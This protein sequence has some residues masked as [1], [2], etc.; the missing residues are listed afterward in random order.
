M[1]R[2]LTGIDTAHGPSNGSAPPMNGLMGGHSQ[3]PVSD[4]LPAP[5]QIRAGTVRGLGVSSPTRWDIMPEIPTIAEAGVTGFDAVNWTLAA[6]PAGT[7]KE[8]VDS[9]AAEFRAV[10]RMP[11]AKEQTAKL[12]R[13][14]PES[15]PPDQLPQFV[16][17]E[18]VRWSNVVRQAGLVGTL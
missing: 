8:I 10:A 5:P 18:T 15:P 9:L 1:F 7:P 4:P 13:V 14:L 3:M 2:S 12:G 6:A 17:A 16:A 11:E